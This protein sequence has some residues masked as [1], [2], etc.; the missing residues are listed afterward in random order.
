M[1]RPLKILHLEDDSLAAELVQAR[2]ESDGF[3]CEIVRVDTRDGFI[4]ALENQQFDLVLA[5]Y[6]LPSFDGLSALKIAREKC[7]EVPY[8]F[9]SGQ[10]GEDIAVEALKSGATDYVLKDRL[11]R[12]TPAIRRALKEAEDRAERRQAEENVKKLNRVYAVLSAV[13]HLI[14]R[15]SARQELFE[16]A[17]RVLVE[18]G[19]FK[20]AW[21][22]LVD[23]DTRTVRPAACSGCDD[24]YLKSVKISIDPV[25]E[26]DGP[27]GATVRTGRHFINN[28]T[29]NNPLML[30]W[31]DDALRC[32]YLSS[33]AF[34]LMS[35]GKVIGALTV[36]GSERFFFDDEEVRLLEGLAADISHAVRSMEQEELRKRAESESRELGERLQ[37]LVEDALVG[38]YIMQDNRFIY[39]NWRIAE[40]LGY[41]KEEILG[42]DAVEMVHPDDR[43]KVRENIRMRI[44]EK[45]K[46]LHSEFRMLKKDGGVVFVEVLSSY[47][48][49]QG[50]PSI[51]GSLL[52]IS[53]RK[54]AEEKIIR[55]KTEWERTFDTVPDLISIIDKDHQIMRVNEAMASRLGL[56]PDECVGLHCFEGVHGTCMPPEFCPHSR[57]IADGGQNIQEVHEP[58]LGG[59]FIVSTTPMFDASGEFLGSVHVAHDITERKRAEEA[60]LASEERYHSLFDNS[61]DAVFL[62]STD[63]RIL[64]ANSAA[65]RMFGYG[66][67][68]MLR[69]DKADI[70]DKVDGRFEALVRERTEKGYVVGECRFLRKDGTSFEGEMSSMIFK[71]EK[72]DGKISVIIRDITGRKELEQQ[73]A[74]FYA[75]ITHDL[76]SPLTTILGYAEFILTERVEKLDPEIL[77]M[78]EAIQSSSISLH[79]MSDDFLAVS[80]F[81]SGVL[82]LNLA[83]TEI[84]NILERVSKDLGSAAHEKGL[85]LVEEIADGLPASMMD[86]RLV[87]RALA[88]LLQNAIIYTPEGGKVILK[89]EKVGGEVVVSVTD[90]GLGIPHGEQARV[91][92]KYYR[93]SRTSY[94]KGTGLGLAIVKAVAEAHGGRVELESEEGKGSTFRIFLPITA[95]RGET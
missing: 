81:E 51:I 8:I 23:E 32:G 27:T 75:M 37:S 21:V 95:V 86:Q 60:L 72:G 36:Y 58:R 22:G 12:L 6:S 1:G 33:A 69:L 73:K 74:D 38:A 80:K 16:G 34:P 39:V 43:A 87:H 49:Y 70:T 19:L 29:E 50:K 40:I 85:L 59:H 90:T 57:T 94:I 46:D 61:N 79:Q 4:S 89:A 47:T 14:I 76:K 13:N 35:D 62:I 52:D 9:I 64:D 10:M 41:S 82:T 77:E 30:P 63:D 92:E 25:P 20:M 78:V 2:L 56:K 7:P 48:L 18:E 11:S 66:R 44:E 67:E 31:R 45:V 53:E 91:F 93:S 88:N 26:G 71:D 24:G 83:P 5:D 15:T 17:C 68:E 3:D 65:G 55:A 84:S 54:Q 42:K 28:D